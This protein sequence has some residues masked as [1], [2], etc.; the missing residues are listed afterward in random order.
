MFNKNR[1]QAALMSPAMFMIAAMLMVLFTLGGCASDRA[2]TLAD[3]TQDSSPDAA[4]PDSASGTEQGTGTGEI[5]AS[6]SGQADASNASQE[7]PQDVLICV[8]VCGCVNVPGVYELPAGSRICDAL[9]AAG[10]MTEEAE[11][12]R[13]NLAALLCD[14]DMIYFPGEGEEI[15]QGASDGMGVHGTGLVN[16]NLADEELLCTLPGIGPSKARAIIRYREE[17]GQ[18]TDITQIR[19]VSGIGESLYQGIADLICV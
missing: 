4:G 15:P 1:I 12:G 5:S 3:I 14:G 18:F 17:H 9:N 8:Y 2:V 7:S 19:N 11:E 6:D 13:I 16:I 10:G